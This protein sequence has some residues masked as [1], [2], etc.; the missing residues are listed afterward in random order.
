MGMTLFNII[1]V[2]SYFVMPF[3][4]LTFI[5]SQKALEV[6]S[7]VCMVYFLTVLAVGV[8]C[9]ISF[10]PLQAA[11]K[12]KGSFFD[13]PIKWFSTSLTDTITNLFMLVPIGMY[14]VINYKKPLQK[15]IIVGL[16]FGFLI[17]FLQFALPI[18][19][20]PQVSDFLFNAISCV[21]GCLIALLALKLKNIIYKNKAKK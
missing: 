20:G 17:E 12:V 5:K 7:K 13:K 14:I 16:V 10:D 6:M 15:S 3:I 21:I 9:E 19:R 18:P 8:F 2:L 11:I 1:I 4:C